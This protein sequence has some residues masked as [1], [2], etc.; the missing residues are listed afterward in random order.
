MSTRILLA[1]GS[2][3]VFTFLTA[4][5]SFRNQKDKNPEEIAASGFAVLE[6]FT[7]EGCSSCPPADKLL[8]EIQR[9]ATGKEIYVL[10]YHVD[11]WNRLGW[12][13]PFSSPEFS[14]RQY[15]YGKKLSSQV[16]TPQLIING[17]EELIG[18]NS[19]A[20]KN[21]LS[22][23]LKRKVKEKLHLKAQQEGG[24]LRID[25]SLDGELGDVEL[26]IA[27]VRK[28][29][30]SRVR[31]G[32]NSGRTLSHVQ[33]VERLLSFDIRSGEPVLV[34]PPDSFNSQEW[35]LIGFLQSKDKGEI[36]AATRVNLDDFG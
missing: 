10:A 16:Y 13:D 27:I 21:S 12:V 8:T 36:S 29:A 30:V 2:A 24:Q 18:S 28:R 17:K 9:Q 14:R 22:K 26:H 4:T 7:S 19:T 15:Q 35:E 32:E 1:V 3:I 11:Y 6:L 34:S 33:I 25:Y 5:I 20:V 31:S 23:A